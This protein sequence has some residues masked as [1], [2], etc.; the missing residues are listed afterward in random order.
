MNNGSSNIGAF[1]EVEIKRAIDD[2]ENGVLALS[3]ST[4][5][6]KLKRMISSSYQKVD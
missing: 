1:Y 6:D 5:A 4:Q 3:S 2:I